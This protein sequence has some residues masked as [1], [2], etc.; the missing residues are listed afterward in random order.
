MRLPGRMP[1]T[2][3][4]LCTI[5]GPGFAK[6]PASILAGAAPVLPLRLPVSLEGLRLGTAYCAGRRAQVLLP[7]D[8]RSPHM[9]V[10][11]E[12][13]AG[14]TTYCESLVLGLVAH[15]HGVVYID[16]KGAHA[17]RLALIL[18]SRGYEEKLRIIDPARADPPFGLDPIKLARSS[19]NPALM[20]EHLTAIIGHL[21]GNTGPGPRQEALTRCA[22]TILVQIPGSGLAQL[23]VL[24]LDADWRR[25]HLPL[26]NDE[27]ARAFLE[28][29]LDRQSRSEA[30]AAA[31]PVVNAL[32]PILTNPFFR[33]LITAEPQLDL[34]G[35]LG[36]GE[37]LIVN[38]GEGLIGPSGSGLLTGVI[39]SLVQLTAAGRLSHSTAGTRDHF[40]AIDEAHR[41]P[42]PV[43]IKL[44]A[45]G[46]EARLKLLLATQSLHGVPSEVRSALDANAAAW[47]VFRVGL[48]DA[49][50]VAD[51]FGRPVTAEDL[52]RQENYRA[53]M[54]VALPGW[55]PPPFTLWTDPPLDLPPGDPVEEDAPQAY[56][57]TRATATTSAPLVVGNGRRRPDV[58]E[59]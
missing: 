45:E 41:L 33:R 36:K 3:Q 46:R 1:L 31:L 19:P 21:T 56:D 9:L 12:T 7:L 55:M 11:G 42:A 15:M 57:L 2:L 26:A 4:E 29:Q 13:G 27:E 53:T 8:G 23:P 38:A 34:Y 6:R 48:E 16:P 58:D 59:D 18:R 44:L 32:S 39:A 14:K 51:K 43:V 28:L 40:L 20:V 52:M 30:F 17:R 25:A 47:C 24:L 35:L 50:L 37:H 22:C 49:R 10:L 5:W 54:R